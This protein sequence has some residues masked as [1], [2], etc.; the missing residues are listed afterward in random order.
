MRR[1]PAPAQTLGVLYYLVDQ[2]DAAAMTRDMRMHRQE[3]QTTLL[4]GAIEFGLENLGNGAWRGVG[5][6][7]RKAHEVEIHRVV[8]GLE[9]LHEASNVVDIPQ[10]IELVGIEEGEPLGLLFVGF[11]KMIIN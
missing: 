7:R 2:S 11:E 6:Q 3:E 8:V 9:R 4:P 10:D 1:E 5:A